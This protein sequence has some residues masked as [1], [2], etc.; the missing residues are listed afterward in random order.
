MRVDRG[1]EAT[2]APKIGLLPLFT[3][4]DLMA[5]PMVSKHTSMFQGGGDRELC[6]HGTP[7]SGLFWP[8]CLY[9]KALTRVLRTFWI[10]KILKSVPS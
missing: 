10:P 2:D 5:P 7:F 8:F 9:L 6:T 1:S 3:T 4:Q